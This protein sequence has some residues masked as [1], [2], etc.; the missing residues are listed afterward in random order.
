MGDV[1]AERERSAAGSVPR[2]AARAQQPR[3]AP[4]P[5]RP[6]RRRRT[7]VPAEARARSRH[8][9]G[10]RA[11]R[12]PAQSAVCTR[13]M[14]TP[15][16]TGDQAI[17]HRQ[18][19]LAAGRP[20]PS[21]AAPRAQRAAAPVDLTQ[22]RHPLRIAPPTEPAVGEPGGQRQHRPAVRRRDPPRLQT[23]AL[24][25]ARTAT[26]RS[27]EARARAQVRP[28]PPTTSTYRYL[29]R[30]PEPPPRAMRLVD[31][32]TARAACAQIPV[33]KLA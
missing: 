30:P 15:S 9:A 20:R 7:H 19:P 11:A 22:A 25:R 13:R 23:P 2:R 33:H 32:A 16:R 18:S 27:R 28:H 31:R 12:L 6:R 29:P 26:S 24:G 5:V 10:E 14:P 17:A 4:E 3:A 8:P 21:L 1:A